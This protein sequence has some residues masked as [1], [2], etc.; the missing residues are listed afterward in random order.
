MSLKD[1][2]KLDCTCAKNREA[3]QERTQGPFS[4]T[5]EKDMMMT[6]KRLTTRQI[7][8]QCG[9]WI[10]RCKGISLSL[11]LRSASEGNFSMGSTGFVL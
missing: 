4:L 7:L 3:W 5:E 11:F 6:M 1:E 2:R 10:I 8:I 9:D